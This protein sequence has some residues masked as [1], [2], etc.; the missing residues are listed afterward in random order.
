MLFF[1][2]GT[3]DF[4][5]IAIQNMD[6][7]TSQYSAVGVEYFTHY[8]I[9]LLCLFGFNILTGVAGIVIAHFNTG[10]ASRLILISGS[11]NLI[12]IF[13]TVVFMNRIENIGFGMTLQ[14]SSVMLGTFGLYFY[15]RWLNKGLHSAKFCGT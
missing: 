7:L 6:Y 10:W 2:I 8:P 12:L 5:N 1:S 14:D 15:Y 9:L 3:Y 13:I 4:I 11:A